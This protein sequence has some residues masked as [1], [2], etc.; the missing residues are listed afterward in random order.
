MGYEEA[1]LAHYKTEASHSSL[2]KTSTMHD[3]YIKDK[4]V[5]FI[6]AEI[7]KAVAQKGGGISLLEIGC[8][9]GYLLSVL[10]EKFPEMKLSALEFTKELFDLATSRKLHG[11]N[12]IHGDCRQKNFADHE[13]DVVVCERV[14]INLLEPKDQ[15][16]AL[17]N[18]RD[19]LKSGGQFVTVECF[20]EP[21]A[22]LNV[23]RDE[24]KMSAILP[25][26]HNL[27]L[28]ENIVAAMR[29]FGFVEV[30]GSL[31]K[32]TLSTHFFVTRIIHEFFKPEGGKVK[33]TEFARFFDMALPPAIGNYSP[34]LFR[35]FVKKA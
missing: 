22:E 26:H 5:E 10:K 11:V 19:S 2:D 13:F 8:G 15:V 1:V 33:N 34:L 31:P 3:V 27:Y 4:E 29:D 23:I 20:E 6:L 25:A 18:I 9:N 14:L 21:L 17:G 28:S 12:I 24:M 7:E 16:K 30:V 32:N 35:T